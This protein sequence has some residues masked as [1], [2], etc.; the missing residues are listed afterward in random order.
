LDWLLTKFKH[1]QKQQQMDLQKFTIKTQEA[2]QQAQNIAENKKITAET[3]TM[4]LAGAVIIALAIIST[5][6]KR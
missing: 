3:S 4:L 1:I 2:I 6:Y 5:N